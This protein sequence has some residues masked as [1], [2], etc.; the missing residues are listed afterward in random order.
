MSFGRQRF[1]ESQDGQSQKPTMAQLANLEPLTDQV[2]E[3]EF[4][5]LKEHFQQT[6]QAVLPGFFLPKMRE[7]MR[8]IVEG[9]Q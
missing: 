7:R 4:E 6:G 2:V 1:F 8:T 5:A 3:Q 9:G